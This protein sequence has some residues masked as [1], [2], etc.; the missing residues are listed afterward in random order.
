MFACA[1]I[2][3]RLTYIR[4]SS[5]STAFVRSRFVLYFLSISMKNLRTNILN[6]AYKLFLSKNVEKV[7]IAELENALKKTRGT[8]F[9]HFSNKQNLF[10]AV[11]DEIFLPLSEISQEAI[12]MANYVPLKM[13]VETYK[14][15]EERVIEHIRSTFQISEPEISYYNFLSQA[16]KYYSG[17]KEKYTAIIIKDLFVWEIVIKKAQ[18]DNLFEAG[19]PRETAYIFMLLKRGL[20][21][22][23]GYLKLSGSEQVNNLLCLSRYLAKK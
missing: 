4:F 11:V 1:I 2:L 12:K 13:F 16:H 18:N 23:N 10:E 17:F 15:P 3:Y 22:S 20:I 14:S 5:S 6:E 9:Y 7:T 19:L 8:I 21:C